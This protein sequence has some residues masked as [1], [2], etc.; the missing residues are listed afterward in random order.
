MRDS[1][2]YNVLNVNN[3][4]IHEAY[5]SRKEFVPYAET[6]VV[7]TEQINAINSMILNRKMILFVLAMIVWPKWA[8]KLINKQIALDRIARAERKLKEQER[9]DFEKAESDVDLA[10]EAKKKVDDAAK[11]QTPKEAGIHVI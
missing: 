2:I 9:A 6:L 1:E 10:A 5:T 11:T 3:K 4:K 7:L 8:T